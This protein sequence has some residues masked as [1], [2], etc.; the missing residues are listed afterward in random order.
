[1]SPPL[2]TT[3]YEGEPQAQV[4]ARLRDAGV[5]LLI[6]VRAVASS[7]RPGFSKSILASS[8]GEAGIAYLHLRDLGTPKDGRAAVR[9]GRPDEMRAIYEAHLLT[10]SAHHALEHAIAES[11]GRRAC[12]LC[13][14]TDP[15]CC[16]RRIVAERIRART[17]CGV[18]DLRPSGA[19]A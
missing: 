5:E 17:G 1:M 2:F 16:H 12:L 18:E 9:A 7:R 3:G 11:L 6:D 19:P 4:I 8:L 13:Y 10:T 15:A 14:E